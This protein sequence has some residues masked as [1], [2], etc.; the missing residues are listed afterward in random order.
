MRLEGRWVSNWDFSII[1][2]RATGLLRTYR[3]R[4]L[5]DGWVV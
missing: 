3:V 2:S 5:L 4:F 1:L